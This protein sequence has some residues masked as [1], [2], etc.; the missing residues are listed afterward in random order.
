MTFR[1]AE[2]KLDRIAKAQ[3]HSITYQRTTHTDGRRTQQC[4]LYVD[5]SSL[6]VASTWAEAFAKLEEKL[7]G[8]SRVE[9][10]GVLKEVG[11]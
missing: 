5:P 1:Q 4:T 8:V 11:E 2:Q 9:D 6:A 7:T 10:V 3:Y